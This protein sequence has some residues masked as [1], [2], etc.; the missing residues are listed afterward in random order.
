MGLFDRIRELFN[1]NENY[2]TAQAQTQ[3]NDY[4]KA[5]LSEQ[6]VDL[7]RRISIK[8]SLN[9]K[10]RNMHN[11]SAYQLKTKDLEELDK[12]YHSLANELSVIES[13]SQTRDSR[14]EEIEASRWTGHKREGMSDHD[15]DWGQR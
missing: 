4:E 3:N 12:L 7:V 14:S 8:D 10:V 2:Q 6:I 13:K 9:S 5:Q 11:I 1:G 15:F